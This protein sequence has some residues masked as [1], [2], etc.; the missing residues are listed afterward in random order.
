MRVATTTPRRG[1]VAFP[2]GK[3]NGRALFS[4][5]FPSPPLFSAAMRV[6]ASVKRLCSACKIVRR[7]RRVYNVCKENPRH[8]QRQ[9][10]AR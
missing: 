5:P 4:T 8:K 3:V 2:K 7:R 10:F 1:G 6:R 9:G